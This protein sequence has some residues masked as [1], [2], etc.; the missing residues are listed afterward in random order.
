MQTVA[1]DTF[2]GTDD[3]VSQG[4]LWTGRALSGLAVLFMA[5]DSLG[6]LLR[7]RR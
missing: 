4:A 6:K 2:T 1:Q 5:F 7:V 3:A